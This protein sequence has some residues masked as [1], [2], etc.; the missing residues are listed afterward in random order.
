L[1]I[2]NNSY[3]PELSDAVRAVVWNKPHKH[4]WSRSDVNREY[5]I[6]ESHRIQQAGQLLCQEF[7]QG[8]YPEQASKKLQQLLEHYRQKLQ[9][10]PK[11]FD[12]L[13]RILMIE[14]ALRYP[15]CGI[16][17]QEKQEYTGGKS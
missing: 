2:C 1:L 17:E 9:E 8:E 16:D 3:A 5:K 15:E 7:V 6:G 11:D 12:V 10:N 4:Y 13:S 14:E